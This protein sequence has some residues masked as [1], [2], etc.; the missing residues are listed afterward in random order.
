LT[1]STENRPSRRD[2]AGFDPKLTYSLL[3]E[4]AGAPDMAGRA[5]AHD[6]VVFA[7][8]FEFEGLVK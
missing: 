7:A 3:Q 6:E 8:G 1:C 5:H 2:F 4:K